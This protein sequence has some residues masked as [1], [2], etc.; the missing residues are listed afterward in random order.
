MVLWFKLAGHPIAFGTQ[1]CCW[2]YSQQYNLY[3]ILLHTYSLLWL[4]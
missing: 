1:I 2:T 4:V 3:S